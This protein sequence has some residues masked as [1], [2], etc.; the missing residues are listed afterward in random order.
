MGF[1]QAQAFPHDRSLIVQAESTITIRM[2]AKRSAVTQGGDLGFSV[3]RAMA[4]QYLQSYEAT[5]INMAILQ[6]PTLGEFPA[7]YARMK[8]TPLIDA[9]KAGIGRGNGSKRKALGIFKLQAT[10]S[11]AICCSMADPPV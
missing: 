3:T 10:K 11:Q 5:H 8:A 6:E 7:L 9:E 2:R 4:L 1:N